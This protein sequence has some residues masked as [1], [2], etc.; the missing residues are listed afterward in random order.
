M[1]WLDLNHHGNVLHAFANPTI[2]WI[3]LKF[4]QLIEHDKLIILEDIGRP[5]DSLPVYFERV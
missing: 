2:S 1:I 5:W 4:P 3:L